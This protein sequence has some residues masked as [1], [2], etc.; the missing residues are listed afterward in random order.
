M[1]HLDL[2]DERLALRHVDALV[3]VVLDG[4][5]VGRDGPHHVQVGGQPDVVDAGVVVVAGGVQLRA[6]GFATNLG[7]ALDERRF[8][9]LLDALHGRLVPAGSDHGHAQLQLGLELGRRWVQFALELHERRL[10]AAHDPQTVVPLAVSGSVGRRHRR[11]VTFEQQR[12]TR[13]TFHL[14]HGRGVLGAALEVPVDWRLQRP[15][16][17]LCRQVSRLVRFVVY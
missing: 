7:V 13:T 14:A 5:V 11:L 1:R 16:L 15:T 12:M 6:V 10:V 4:R 9:R 2:L 8:E 3:V 17:G